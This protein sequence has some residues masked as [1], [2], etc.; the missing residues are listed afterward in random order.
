MQT[1]QTQKHIRSKIFSTKKSETYE[2]FQLSS[3][4]NRVK[5]TF[6]CKYEFKE[7]INSLNEEKKMMISKRSKM[8]KC[9]IAKKVIKRK[10]SSFFNKRIAT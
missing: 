3:Q 10:K 1:V 5:S 6:G 4:K 7:N 2:K 9:S 8:M